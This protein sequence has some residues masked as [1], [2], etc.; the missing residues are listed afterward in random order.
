MQIGDKEVYFLIHLLE[1]RFQN[2]FI[3]K[4]IVPQKNIAFN[5]TF[6]VFT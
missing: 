4:T 1:V 2:C 5:S 3:N 6:L